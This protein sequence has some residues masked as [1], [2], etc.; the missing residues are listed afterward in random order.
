MRAFCC[1]AAKKGTASVRL[2]HERVLKSW[3]RA[4]DIVRDNADFYR[5]RGHVEDQLEH[6]LAAEQVRRSADPAG[7]SARRGAE[8]RR[9]YGA[10]L[11]PKCAAT[12][13]HRSPPTTSA[14]ARAAYAS[15]SPQRQ[16]WC[17]PASR[18]LPAGNG[19]W[20]TSRSGSR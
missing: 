19:M 20:P 5:M 7:P 15:A 17:S 9:R 10:E 14:P 1:R 4:A 8:A 6:W 18:S 16:L 11:E 13:S 12:S 3:K 2:A